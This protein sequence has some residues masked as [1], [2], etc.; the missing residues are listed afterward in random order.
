MWN[1]IQRLGKIPH[2]PN[3]KSL[4]KERNGQLFCSKKE[5]ILFTSVANGHA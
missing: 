2:Y 1:F 5:S 4:K 3:C